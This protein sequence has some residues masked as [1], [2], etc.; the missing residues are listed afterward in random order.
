[1]LGHNYFQNCIVLCWFVA[2]CHVAWGIL[3]TPS[4]IHLY[5]HIFMC[6]LRTYNPVV[7]SHVMALL[8]VNDG[9]GKK[10]ADAYNGVDGV[11]ERN[12]QCARRR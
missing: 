8:I 9:Y 1:M 5:A 7:A 6:N 3:I 4:N 11:R 10:E 12:V 2:K